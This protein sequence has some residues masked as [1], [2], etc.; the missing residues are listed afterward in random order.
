[1]P[2]P[3]ILTSQDTLEEQ[4][5]QQI[6]PFWQSSVSTGSFDSDD[7]V[8]IAYAYC[9][10]PDAKATVVVS[11]GR[12]EGYL[13]YKEF[14]FDLYQN[15]FSVFIIDH[16]GQGLSGR[17]ID[18]PQKGFVDDF[19]HYVDD[20]H[21]FYHHVVAPK[22]NGPLFLTGHSMGGTIATLYLQQNPDDFVGAA[23]SAPLYGFHPGSIPVFLAKPVSW[24]LI[25]LKILLGQSKD[26][27]IGQHDYRHEPFEGNDLTHCQP[28]YHHFREQYAHEPAL[29]LGGITFHWLATALRAI[30][31]LYD[32]LENI[33]TP[34]L[35]IQSC[36]DPIVSI[37]A[38]SRV[39][40]RLKELGECQKIE[41]HGAKHEVFFETDLMRNTAIGGMLGF[42]EETIEGLKALHGDAKARRFTEED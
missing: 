22:A 27:F 17:L 23:M 36:D 25:G 42:F 18:D 2:S 15:G 37:R 32:K 4:F 1:M 41:L 24:V 20:L 38:Q 39:H 31:R 13:K 34:M 26:Y 40:K 21:Y 5:S 28:R 9:L 19:Q 16:R 14:I 30:D 7:G 35:I 6:E 29:Q 3:Y 12:T 10:C 8:S 11:P 33:K